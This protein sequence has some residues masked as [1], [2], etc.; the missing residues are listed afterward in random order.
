MP[1]ILHELTI[2]KQPDD[3]FS[4]LTEGEKIKKWWTTRA[5]AQPQA[6]TLAEFGFE[7][8]MVFKFRVD[9]LTAGESVKWSVVGGGPPDWAGTYVTW[10]LQPDDKGTKLL[11]GHHNYQTTQGSFASVN[12]SWAWFLTSLK[13]YLE[14]GTGTPYSD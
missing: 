14:K 12:Y 4:A 9:E 3:V 13:S 5:K 1:D 10:A 2:E 6:G 11:F 8:D 7:N